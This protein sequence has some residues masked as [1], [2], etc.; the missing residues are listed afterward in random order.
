MPVLAVTPVSSASVGPRLLFLLPPP[1][2]FGFHLPLLLPLHFGPDADKTSRPTTHALHALP[3][4]LA[5]P[6]TSRNQT[7][8]ASNHCLAHP[9]VEESTIGPAPQVEIQGAGPL[10]QAWIMDP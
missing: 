1:S 2:G 5:V 6:T 4:A 9:V 3:K 7:T 10:A 8:L